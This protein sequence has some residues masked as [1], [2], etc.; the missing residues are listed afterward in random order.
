MS[1]A[2]IVGGRG[3]D[4][5]LLLEHL[6]AAG[7][8]TAV[9]GRGEWDPRNAEDARRIL[10][11]RYTQ[12]YYLAAYHHSSQETAAP[13]GESELCARSY[14]VHVQGAVHFL[15]AIRT[16]FPATRFF[17]AASSLVFGGP[18][19]PTQDESTPFSPQCVY[20]I[21]KAAGVQMCR[22]FRQ[23][24]GVFASVGI[25]FNHESRWRARRFVISKIV[26]GAV[27]I[28]RGVQQT[29]ALGDLEARVDWGYAPDFVDAMHRILCLEAPEDF[30]VATGRTHSVGE[31]AEIAFSRL[32][33]DWRKHVVE[34]SE[35]LTRK[36]FILCGDASKLRRMCGWRPSVDFQTL[37]VRLL[38][39]A[40]NEAP[41]N[42]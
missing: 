5:R 1:R 23:K 6:A 26:H 29:L 12:V 17:Y 18:Q 39:A 28:A 15:E 32:G 30:V 14:E 35:I 16:G 38:E 37:I 41:H 11:G 36:R 21:S 27:A 33:L 34:S 42:A 40:Q 2:L 10:A 19:T 13:V 22:Y 31:A 8:E 3:Q 4:G 25:L 20:G 24:H 9:L 7:V